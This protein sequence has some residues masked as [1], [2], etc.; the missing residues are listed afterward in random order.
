[1]SNMP[2]TT[3]HKHHGQH[4]GL[5]AV[6]VLATTTGVVLT[7]QPRDA[8]EP[9]P[10]ANVTPPP[11]PPPAATPSLVLRGKSAI[12]QEQTYQR[13][14]RASGTITFD[15][16]RTA[17]VTVP[18]HGWLKK[19]RAKT[20]GRTVRAGETLAIV[21]S[22]EVYLAT[23]DLLAQINDFHSQEAVD[24]QR[25]RLLRWGMSRETL[26][27]IERANRPSAALPIIARVG[28]LVVAEQGPREGLTDPWSAGELFTITDPG[29]TWLYIDAPA[30]DA[31]RV[32]PKLWARVIVEARKPLTADVGYVFRRVEAG[33]RTI[34]LELHTRA[35]K[36]G[37]AAEAELGLGT[38]RRPVVPPSA[39]R[40]EAG[41]TIVYV[42][43]DGNTL[44]P[45]EVTL[46]PLTE[47]GYPIDAGLKA[48]ET[49]ATD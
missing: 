12:V 6:L 30:A 39:V 38:E 3:L 48:G 40:R 8:R 46:G 19:A 43:R 23:Q 42:V 1:M 13:T 22:P 5:I 29:S 28:G 20:L 7:S 33:L 9:A 49:I 31:A 35:V 25:F 36:P 16:D 34:R 41:A 44:E 2:V 32:T 15:E 21:Y 27:A 45:R 17:H 37:M 18:V 4:G 14:I 11:P 47:A 10:K 24:A 26:A